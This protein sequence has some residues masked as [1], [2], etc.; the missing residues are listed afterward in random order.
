MGLGEGHGE[1]LAWPRVACRILS[2]DATSI[3]RSAKPPALIA[4]TRISALLR[5][6]QEIP[7]CVCQLHSSA[8]RP[9]HDGQES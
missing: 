4:E 8:A 5:N 1:M 3:S 9:E 7:H 6:T 2:G